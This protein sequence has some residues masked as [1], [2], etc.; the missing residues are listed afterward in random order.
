MLYMYQCKTPQPTDWWDKAMRTCTTLHSHSSSPYIC[1]KP[2][3]LTFYAPMWDK[4]IYNSH[5]LKFSFPFNSLTLHN[6]IFMLNVK[7]VVQ[8]W[9][10]IFNSQYNA[11]EIVEVGTYVECLWGGWGACIAMG[12]TEVLICHVRHQRVQEPSLRRI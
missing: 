10:S 2:A 6:Q 9:A 12:T 11:Q 3:I 8:K 4:T 7:C 1:H 5:I